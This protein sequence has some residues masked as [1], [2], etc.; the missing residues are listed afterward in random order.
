MTD[1]IAEESPEHSVTESPSKRN[2]SPERTE[3]SPSLSKTAKKNKKNREK[4]KQNKVL[5]DPTKVMQ[6]HDESNLKLTSTDPSVINANLKIQPGF[7]GKNAV[8]IEPVQVSDGMAEIKHTRTN[9]EEV[10][11]DESLETNTTDRPENELDHRPRSNS[12]KEAMKDKETNHDHRDLNI[13]DTTT[14]ILDKF[15][16]TNKEDHNSEESC[17]LN[18]MEHGSNIPSDPNTMVPKVSSTTET[19]DESLNTD[20]SDAQSEL[21]TAQPSPS[22]PEVPISNGDHRKPSDHSS[23]KKLDPSFLSE[24]RTTNPQYVTSDATS[25][26][27]QTRNDKKYTLSEDHDD[28]MSQNTKTDSMISL[29]DSLN[30]KYED[31]N[32]GGEQQ[33]NEPLSKRATENTSS[34]EIS[35]HTTDLLHS[36]SAKHAI[37]TSQHASRTDSLNRLSRENSTPIDLNDQELDNPSMTDSAPPLPIRPDHAVESHESIT[38]EEE[39]QESDIIPENS[40]NPIDSKPLVP[41]LPPRR[42]NEIESA[43]SNSDSLNQLTS[44]LPGEDYK[45]RSTRKKNAVPPSLQDELKSENFRKNLEQTKASSMANRP[46]MTRDVTASSQLETSAEVNLIANRFRRTSHNF[47]R[48][49]DISKESLEEGQYLLRESYTSFVSKYAPSSGATIHEDQADQELQDEAVTLSNHPIEE[50]LD[51]DE[52]DFKTINWDFWTELVN[53]YLKVVTTQPDQL[54]AHV[55]NGIPPQIRGIIWQLMTNSKSKEMETI[56]ETLL[57]TKSPFEPNIRRDLT[58]TNFIPDD[59][60]EALF[61]VIKTYSVY[62]PEVGY[63]QGM[64]FI[65]TPLILN[66]NTEAEA[67][68]LLVGLM[69]N[70]SLRTFFSPEL[71]GLMLMLYQFDRILEET[72]PQ[73]HSHLSR[74]GIKSSM[75]ASQWFLTFFAYKFPLEFVL[76]IFDV[77]FVAGIESIMKFGVNLILKNG[78]KVMELQFDELLNFLKDGLFEVYRDSNGIYNVDAFVRD[79]MRDIVITPLSLSRYAGEY[80][81][82]HQMEHERE[83]KYESVRV[84]NHQLHR[85]LNKLERDYAMLDKEHVEVAN[86]LINTRLRIQMLLD[87]KADLEASLTELQDTLQHER[88][89]SDPTTE[90][91]PLAALEQDLEHT[92][93]RNLEVKEENAQME[94]RIRELE[95]MMQ[96]L[97]ALNRAKVHSE[98]SET[99]AHEKPQP[100]KSTSPS[101]MKATWSGIASVFKK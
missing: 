71:P 23:F 83:T 93:L 96:E 95:Q 46:I 15:D 2:P 14:T 101:K 11:A 79:A 73:V 100:A 90:Q 65:V 55:I 22:L 81:E 97:K 66:C 24:Q 26:E 37:Q 85:E 28:V 62:D 8:D 74:A 16:E 52:K 53:D 75:Y 64:G 47:A 27:P 61:R 58:R 59:K 63:T 25:D 51:R 29:N 33:M 4:R 3:K 41:R 6:T 21:F 91:S 70:Y 54:E 12:S 44:S 89:N 92:R 31:N 43:Y 35:K 18:N 19:K 86:E 69:K 1:E 78:N 9:E 13:T 80:E 60:L 10:P 99:G 82:L 77:V 39:P 17:E 30:L 40:D 45:L 42:S 76:R 38:D 84:R 94:D 48:Q 98:H 49:G 34:G 5:S 36:N 88:E 56:Y 57:T 72:V 50:S 7:G 67:F 32:N 20:Q 87:E 68:G